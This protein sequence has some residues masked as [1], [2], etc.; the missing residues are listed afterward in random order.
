MRIPFLRK[1]A[2]YFFELYPLSALIRL[3]RRRDRPGLP[4]RIA[5]CSSRFSATESSWRSPGVSKKV[6]GFPFPSQRMWIFVLNPPWLRPMASS[7]GVLFFDRLRVDESVQYSHPQ[8]GFPSPLHPVARPG[9]GLQRGLYPR[10]RLLSSGESGCRRWPTCRT[11]LADRATE[12]PFAKPTEFHLQS[13]DVP[14]LVGLCGAAPAVRRA[15]FA[16]IVRL[17]S[18][19]CSYR[20]IIRDL[21]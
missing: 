8:N 17:S 2:R 3:G 16:P 14:T 6:T 20:R 12:L 9:S 10:S 15:V 7:T 18:R 4:V 19:L 5:P 13:F 1:Y 11:V 21:L